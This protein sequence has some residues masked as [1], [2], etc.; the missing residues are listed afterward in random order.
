MSR[1][2]KRWLTVAVIWSGVLLLTGW[3]MGLIAR[4]Q[5]GRRSLESVRMDQGYLKA[6]AASVE[7]FLAERSRLTHPVKS[8]GLGFMVVENGL[9]RLSRDC[10]LHQMRVAADQDLQGTGP[11]P[12]NVF[13]SGPLPSMVAWLAA[14]EDAFPYLEIERMDITREDRSRSGQV[15]A[16]FSYRYSLVEMAGGG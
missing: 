11:V 3:N 14:V 16:I 10:G 2:G 13:A 4:V 15:Q 12:I 8:F 6:N 9:K 1:F 5:A 7:R